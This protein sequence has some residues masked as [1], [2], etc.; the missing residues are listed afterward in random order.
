MSIQTRSVVLK[1][2]DHTRLIGHMLS[3]LLSAG[4]TIGLCGPLGA[5]KST[6]ARSIIKT[7]LTSP[8]NQS[9]PSPTYTLVEHYEGAVGSICHFDLYR[10]ESR[11]EVWELGLEEALGSSL[12]LIEWP[13]II[14]DLLPAK[15]LL[16]T[17]SQKQDQRHL[18]VTAQK[19][20]I[21]RL[22]EAQ[23]FTESDTK[24]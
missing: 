18:T 10:L 3:P 23:I 7:L 16:I 13:E 15:S 6:L 4:D 21:E 19:D 2:E 22:E 8:D 11:D 20:W 14:G 1:D 9:V 5:G 12:C 24:L 17:L